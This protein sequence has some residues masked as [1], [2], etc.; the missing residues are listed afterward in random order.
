MNSLFNEALLLYNRGRF[1]SQI[2]DSEKVE[3]YNFYLLGGS[4]TKKT[5]NSRRICRNYENYRFNH[6]VS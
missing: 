2:L 6:N 5:T 1:S 3:L 4:G